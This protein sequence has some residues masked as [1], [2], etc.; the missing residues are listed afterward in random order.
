MQEISSSNSCVV[1]GICVPDKSPAQYHL[2]LKLGSKLKYLNVLRHLRL[3]LEELFIVLLLE[4]L[5]LL[6]H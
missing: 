3:F 4:T 5:M 2:S 6:K 1:T